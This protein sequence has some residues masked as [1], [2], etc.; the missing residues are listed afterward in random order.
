MKH[1]SSPTLAVLAAVSL[2]TLY[3]TRV[4]LAAWTDPAP[5]A[6]CDD[7][8][9]GGATSL[10]LELGRWEA[11]PGAEL[12][13]LETFQDDAGSYDC[14]RLEIDAA[15][16]GWVAWARRVE[17]EL[18]VGRCSAHFGGEGSDGEITAGS[19][20]KRFER[21]ST[22]AEGTRFVSVDLPLW[23]PDVHPS[24][25][26]ASFCDS[27]AAYWGREGEQVFGVLYDFQQG[28]VVERRSAGEFS[29]LDLL[30]S[31]PGDFPRFRWRAQGSTAQAGNV[32]LSLRGDG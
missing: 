10:E 5:A 24:F 22:T 13:R 17:G 25:A 31:E 6:S 30:F 14:Y 4:A 27:Y 1:P 9:R 8:A 23:D 11:I 18:I 20:L 26:T 7:A 21:V 32:T 19:L 28:A 12:T 2:T 16:R 29:A 3:A 15:F